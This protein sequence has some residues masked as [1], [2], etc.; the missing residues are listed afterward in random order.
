MAVLRNNRSNEMSMN[1]HQRINEVKK[2]IDYIKKEKQV[3]TYKAVT[4]DQVTALIRDHLVEFG[5]NIFPA[6]VTSETVV[7]GT[8]TKNG[9][10][11]VRNEVVYAFDFVNIDDPADKYT[12]SVAAHAIDHGDKAPG[13]ALSYAKKAVVLKVF[14][15]ETGEDDES[16][17]QE[18]GITEERIELL[19][20]RILLA[21]N[22]NDKRTA[23]KL[24]IDECRAAGD[25][26]A[27]NAIKAKV[28]PK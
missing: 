8:T 26:D 4:H 19:A 6:L 5:I 21:A 13:K 27:A 14:E 10:P 15:I 3:E 23:Y 18:A 7:T 1:I 12:A 2:K 24:A 28:E 16:R 20:S 11:Y 22:D 9:A 17:F 25:V